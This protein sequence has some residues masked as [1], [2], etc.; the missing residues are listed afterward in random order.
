MHTRNRGEVVKVAKETGSARA[1]VRPPGGNP[2]DELAPGAPLDEVSLSERFGLSRSPIREA[3]ARLSSEGLVVTLPSRS[4]VV[5][6]IDF[7][8]TEPDARIGLVRICA[9]GVQKWTSLPR[10][11]VEGGPM[12]AV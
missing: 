4:T 7:E 3:L 12:W 6:P 9:G 10:T 11:S 8:G 5:T 2:A 1:Y